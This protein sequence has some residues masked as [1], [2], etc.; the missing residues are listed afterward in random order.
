MYSLG[1]RSLQVPTID[2]NPGYKYQYQG[3]YIDGF[4]NRT[5]NGSY[6]LLGTPKECAQFCGG[7]NFTYLGLE[8]GVECFCGNATYTNER[9]SNCDTP[10]FNNHTYY[11]GGELRIQIYSIAL[12][13]SSSSASI[14]FQSKSQAYT[15]SNYSKSQTSLS[16]CSSI[17]SPV[18]SKLAWSAS[19]IA[20]ATSSSASRMS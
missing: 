18:S 6:A 17:V 5:L 1:G 8:N 19:S 13:I 2:D 4:S 15:A 11:C 14:N 10:C 20:L 12:P 7:S 3:C 16:S 9:A